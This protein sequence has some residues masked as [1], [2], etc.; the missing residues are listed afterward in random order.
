MESLRK[1]PQ[2]CRSPAA[3]NNM[4]VAVMPK[5]PQN[6]QS[7]DSRGSRGE[8]DEGAD[9]EAAGTHAGEDDFGERPKV[10]VE[11]PELVGLHRHGEPARLEIEENLRELHRQL[12]GGGLEPEER[13]HHPPLELG[14]IIPPDEELLGVGEKICPTGISG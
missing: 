8:G 5:A 6:R 13:L 4:M 2:A 1:P 3:P 10:G 11:L 12:V 9:D 7:A 14:G